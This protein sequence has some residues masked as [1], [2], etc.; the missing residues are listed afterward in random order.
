MPLSVP[1]R[2]DYEELRATPLPG[3]EVEGI[4][5]VTG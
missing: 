4:D 2:T 1:I 5:F 3:V